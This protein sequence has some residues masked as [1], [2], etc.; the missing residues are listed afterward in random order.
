VLFRSPR[1]PASRSRFWHRQLLEYLRQNR[2]LLAGTLGSIR[3]LK[4]DIPEAT[5][6]AWL[7][8]RELGIT[9]LA[10]FFESAGVGLSDGSEFEG[11]D[12]M[13][14]N[15]GCPRKT[16]QQALDRIQKVFDTINS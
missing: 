2:D 7:D 15:F 1:V 6:L 13:R 14:L 9:N 4:M 8:G 16:L 10:A 3:G 11:K 12:F 5:Y